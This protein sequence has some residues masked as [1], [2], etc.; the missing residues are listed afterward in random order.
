[1]TLCDLSN[2][3]DLT[4]A[5]DLE[6]IKERTHVPSETTRTR[7]DFRKELLKRD[8]RCAFTGVSAEEGDGMR[9]IPYKRG[10]EVRSTFIYTGMVS[11]HLHFL[12]SLQ[13]YLQ[14]VANRPKDKDNC[15]NLRGIND[16][17][18]GVFVGTNVHRPFDARR[19]VILKVRCFCLPMFFPSHLC[20]AVG[21]QTPN[22]ILSI[23]DIPQRNQRSITPLDVKYPTNARYT[24]N[25]LKTPDDIILSALPNNRDATFKKKNYKAETDGPSAAL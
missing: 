2:D 17:Q 15:N 21:I 1:M 12:R 11:D 10:T 7:E 3:S 13:W 14:I 25:W 20:L 19:L 8:A 18:N 22:H 6:V 24:L 9:I 5:V 23:A 16:I 4:T